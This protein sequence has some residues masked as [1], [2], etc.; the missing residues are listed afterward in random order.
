[1]SGCTSTQARHN[2]CLRSEF[3]LWVHTLWA[4]LYEPVPEGP[5]TPSGHVA[6]K[7]ELIQLRLIYPSMPMSANACRTTPC[8]LSS[9]AVRTP[10]NYC[11]GPSP[12]VDV[13]QRPLTESRIQA[14]GLAHEIQDGYGRCRPGCGRAA[15]GQQGRSC[16]GRRFYPDTT[17]SAGGRPALLRSTPPRQLDRCGRL[18]R[19]D[20]ICKMP[21][22]CK[23]GKAAVTWC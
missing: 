13:I 4:G 5:L 20:S 18:G 12:S 15:D 2:V 3:L 22:L 14:N 10:T 9:Y 17:D 7:R 23:L 16:G 6:E 8:L 19:V 21:A 1:M 11:S